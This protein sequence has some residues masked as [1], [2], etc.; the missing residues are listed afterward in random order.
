[1]AVAVDWRNAVASFSVR[2]PCI[3]AST[4]SEAEA[5]SEENPLRKS[6]SPGT[7]APSFVSSAWKKASSPPAASTMDFSWIMRALRV[8]VISW[9]RGTT[10]LTSPPVARLKVSRRSESEPSERSTM[11]SSYLWESI[12]RRMMS[13]SVL[14]AS[15]SMS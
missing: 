9:V 10:P 1:M 13:A 5:R 6:A 12:V 8:V 15:R 3:F 14:P 7:P 11:P 2:T 4:L